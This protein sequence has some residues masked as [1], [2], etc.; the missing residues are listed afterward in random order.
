[1][2]TENS[3]QTQTPLPPINSLAHWSNL[4]IEQDFALYPVAYFHWNFSKVN[5]K[6]HVLKEAGLT[7]FYSSKY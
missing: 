2:K 3:K 7:S 1:M 4:F 6:I 5:M